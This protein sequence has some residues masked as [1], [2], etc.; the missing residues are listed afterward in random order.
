M[1][2]KLR[3]VSDNPHPV[4]GHRLDG[5]G[6]HGLANR[7]MDHVA[8]GFTGF[9]HAVVETEHLSPMDTAV[10]ATW[11]VRAGL[12]EAQILA[13]II[14]DRCPTARSRMSRPKHPKRA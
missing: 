4:S 8:A 1:G 7:L 6:L 11:M 9:A 3:L 5:A 14:G 13:V 2:A 10:I 12:S